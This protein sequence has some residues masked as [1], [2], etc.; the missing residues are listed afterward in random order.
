MIIVGGWEGGL[1]FPYFIIL[2]I[3]FSSMRNLD[4]KWIVSNKLFHIKE[5]EDVKFE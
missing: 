1:Y 4:K 2:I 5:W 3:D